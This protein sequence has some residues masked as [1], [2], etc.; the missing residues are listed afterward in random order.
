[1]DAGKRTISEI[2]NGTKVLEVPFFQRAYVWR[3]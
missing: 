3:E 1:M 2:F